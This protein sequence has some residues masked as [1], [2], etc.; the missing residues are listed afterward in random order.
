MLID[1]GESSKGKIISNYIANLGYSKIDYVVGT[2]PHTDHIGGLAYIIS[3][4]DIGNIYMPKVISTSKTYENLLNAISQKG[5]KITTAKAG[6]N[7]F[8]DENLNIGIIAPT[9]EYSDL[10]NYSAVVKITYKNR[11][12]LFMGDAETKSEN[13]IISDVSA[14]VIKIGHHGSDTSS[15]QTFVNK[16][17]PKYVIIMVGSNNQ[18]NHPYQLIIDRWINAGARVYRTDINGNIIVI[19]DGESLDVNSS[20]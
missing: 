15:G 17:N 7:I 4:F 12:F 10:N 3:N 8:S 14:D 2:H 18:Y 16:V 1:A 11:K 6:V 19:S 9:G 20:R 13:N 5:L